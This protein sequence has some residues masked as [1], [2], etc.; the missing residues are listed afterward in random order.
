[1]GAGRVVASFVAGISMLAGCRTPLPA[2]EPTRSAPPIASPVDLFPNDLD[3]VVRI[4]AARLRQN[5]NLAPLV[6]DLALANETELLTSIKASFESATAIWIGTR[7]MSDGFH[8]DGMLA[9]ERVGASDDRTSEARDRSP[10]SDPKRKRL[11]TRHSG[12]DAYERSARSRGEPVLEIVMR[13]G[14]IVLATAAEAD[15]VLRVLRTGADENRLDPPA[16][17]LVSFAGRMRAGDALAAAT[18][19]ALLRE[20]TEGLASYTG[21]LDEAGGTDGRGAID[22]EL[23]LLYATSDAA[24]IAAAR[25]KALVARFVAAGGTAGTLADSIKLTEQGASLRLRAEVPFAWLAKLH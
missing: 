13:D 18:K 1:M 9:I 3:F 25:A 7:W 12:L 4:D 10:A 20:W 22:V 19:I 14:G 15:A 21:T 6:R 16:R 5:A 23:V 8:G 17:G 11:V 24:R 2:P